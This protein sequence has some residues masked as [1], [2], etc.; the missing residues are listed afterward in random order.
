MQSEGAGA[1]RGGEWDI[2]IIKILSIIASKT[3]LCDTPLAISEKEYFVKKFNA[4]YKSFQSNLQ[5]RSDV[6]CILCD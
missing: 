5:S 4:V 1:R 2:Y 3:L 6:P